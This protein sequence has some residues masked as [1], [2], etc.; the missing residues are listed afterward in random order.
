MGG[1]GQLDAILQDIESAPYGPE[2]GAIFDYDGTLIAGYSATEFLKDQVM[3]GAMAPKDMIDQF[4][5]VRNFLAKK[6]GF[7]ALMTATANSLKGR[8][9]EWFEE[10]GRRVYRKSIAGS[11]YPESRAIV[12]AHMKKGHTVAIISSATKYQI[13]PVAEDLGIEHVLCTELEVENGVFTGGVVRPTCFGEGKR[14][15]AEKL[16]SAEGVNLFETYFY[17]DSDDDLELLE[18]IGHP[19]I[20]NANRRLQAIADERAW[21]SYRFTSRGRPELTDIVRTSMAY[22]AMPAAFMAAAPVWALSGKKR[23]MLNTAMGM[24]ADYASAVT[25]LNIHVEGEEH[26][27]S[28]RPAVFVF[29]HQSSVDMLIV[30]KLIR[31]DVTGVGKKEIANFPVIGP[32]M[33]FA[34]VVLI[35]RKDSKKAI[36]AMKPVV[37]AIRNDRLSVAISP[38]GTRSVSTHLGPFKKGAFHIAMQAGV[39]VVPIVIHNALDSLPR[40]RNIARPADISV[41]VL[42]PVETSKWTAATVGLH[43]NEI[44]EMMAHALDQ[45]AGRLDEDELSLDHW[46]EPEDDED[47]DEDE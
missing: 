13:Q 25:G 19:R 17:T 35:D 41:T 5:A 15:A 7:S 39:P 40:G 8:S 20:L 43:A 10:T 45:G 33:K 22:G 14:L 37:D 21:P 31:R 42:P 6:S 12:S 32:L 36:E 28:Q 26:L 1:S 16:A 24:W 34:D 30:T 38:E 29:N 18:A 47:E 11:V 23:E 2:V 44:R 46:D 3:S 9:E 27:W 4:S